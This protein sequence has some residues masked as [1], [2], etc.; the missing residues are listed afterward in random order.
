MVA[1]IVAC[2]VSKIE[3]DKMA[4]MEVD[5]VADNVDDM[6]ADIEVDK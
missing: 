4:G 3:V 6:V 5:K 2:I 1:N